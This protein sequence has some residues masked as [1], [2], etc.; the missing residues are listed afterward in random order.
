M[1]FRISSPSLSGVFISIGLLLQKW[2]VLDTTFLSISSLRISACVVYY[3]ILGIVLVTWLISGQFSCSVVSDSLWPH[4]LQCA[5]LPCPSPTPRACSNSCP[6]LWWCHPTISACVIPSS[7]WPQYF[8]ASGSF[9]MSLFFTSFDQNIG[10][11]WLMEPV[12]IWSLNKRLA[13][14]QFAGCRL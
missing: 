10:V 5:R 4:G 2:G 14:T 11:S 9:Q 6:L 1:Y 3:S 7:S 8:P 13:D 12:N